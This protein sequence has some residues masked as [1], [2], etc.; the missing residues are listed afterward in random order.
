MKTTRLYTTAAIIISALLAGCVGYAQPYGYAPYG[1]YAAPYGGY[2]YSYGF[3]PYVGF[4]F[5]G[6]RGFYGHYRGRR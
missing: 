2:G 4:G 5:G 6:G 1:G 3:Q